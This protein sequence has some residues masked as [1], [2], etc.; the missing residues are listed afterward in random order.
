[1]NKDNAHDYL[2]LV[3]A[4]I[5]GKTIQFDDGGNW[6]D[7]KNL[8]TESYDYDEYRIKP[9]PRTFKMWLTPRGTMHSLSEV[10]AGEEDLRW[11]RITVQE[12]LK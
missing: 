9:N 1:M 3:Q 4:L 12:V 5:D 2:P 10:P 7:V 11:E 8:N 6:V